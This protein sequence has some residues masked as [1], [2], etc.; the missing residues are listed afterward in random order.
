MLTCLVLWGS[1]EERWMQKVQDGEVRDPW[2]QRK[3]GALGTRWAGAGVLGKQVHSNAEGKDTFLWS[4]CKE[5]AMPLVGQVPEESSSTTQVLQVLMLWKPA[6]T[7]ESC[8]EWDLVSGLSQLP[9][10]ISTYYG[11]QCNECG[12]T[13]LKT[14]KKKSRVALGC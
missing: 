12:N 6:Q 2:L 13:F 14:F 5:T 1:E 7:T 9:R 3:N 10:C 8:L 4:V 11:L